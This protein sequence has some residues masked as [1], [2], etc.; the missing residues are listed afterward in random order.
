MG[1]DNFGKYLHYVNQTIFN[2]KWWT[3]RRYSPASA[4]INMVLF[5]YDTLKVPTSGTDRDD[6]YYYRDS[7]RYRNRDVRYLVISNNQNDFKDMLRYQEDIIGHNQDYAQIGNAIATK[8]ME[9]PAPI[10]CNDCY[11]QDSKDVQAVGHITPG[12]KQNWAVYPEYFILSSNIVFRV[13]FNFC[14]N[15]LQSNTI[16]YI[17][18]DQ[19]CGWR[20]Q[21]LLR[22]EVPTRGGEPVQGSWRRKRGHL[23]L[24]GPVQ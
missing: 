5:D 20:H 3:W 6:F 18:P 16:L 17:Q 1:N 13:S 8:A 12:Y 14:R 4:S 23:Q 21:V 7:L 24:L 10:T 22:P 15:Y 11:N 9:T 2:Y 19:G